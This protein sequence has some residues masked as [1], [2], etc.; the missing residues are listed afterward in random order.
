MTLNNLFSKL[1]KRNRG[2]YTQFVFCVTF[3]VMLIGSFSTAI[4]SARDSFPFSAPRAIN[5]PVSR[6]LYRRNSPAA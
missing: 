3:A 1:R 6:L 2:N 4:F 5:T